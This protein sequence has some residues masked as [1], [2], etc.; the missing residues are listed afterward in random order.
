MRR[1]APFALVVF[2]TLFTLYALE[3]YL[4]VAKPFEPQS[5][6][7]QVERLR[8]RGVQAY[9]AYIP[10]YGFTVSSGVMP[11]SGVRLVR[12]VMGGDNRSTTVY[13]SDERGFRNPR[14]L[15][16]APLD[17]ALLGDSYAQG[18]NAPEGREIAAVMRRTY[19]RT[20]SLGMTGTGQLAQLAMLREFLPDLRP[21]RVVILYYEGNDIADTSRELL[22]PHLS[23]YYF[24]DG[25]V[26]ELE[27]QHDAIDRQLRAWLDDG[28]QRDLAEEARRAPPP[29]TSMDSVRAIAAL[30]S[31][32]SLW[33]VALAEWRA[34]PT[35]KGRPPVLYGCATRYESLPMTR[36]ELDEVHGDVRAVPDD[37]RARQS[38]PIGEYLAAN[39]LLLGRELFGREIRLLPKRAYLHILLQ[40]RALVERWGGRLYFVYLPTHLSVVD[41]GC[42]PERGTIEEIVVSAGIPFI[43]TT[44]AFK[45]RLDPSSLFVLHLT[46]EGY[47][48]VA[49]Y[50][51]QQLQRLEPPR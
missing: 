12:T 41:P 20:V 21:A 43:D 36:L 35:P 18:Y 39:Q 25:F 9:P 6:S 27:R 45:A 42:D 1:L 38:R 28:V 49:D 13:D 8:R 40:M 5:I 10:A 7:R 44:V 48:V 17:V 19:P 26:Q 16:G 22:N 50:V 33:G 30:T 4:T 29:P 47:R 23:R 24:D 31:L 37:P 3:T 11:L 15:W 34:P 46:T 32:R 14:G 51:V 2:S